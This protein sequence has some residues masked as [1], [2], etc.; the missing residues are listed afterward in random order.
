MPT[1]KEKLD[2]IL[3]KI[4][5]ESERKNILI[6]NELLV[7]KLSDELVESLIREEDLEKKIETLQNT[8]QR[9]AEIHGN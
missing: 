8:I 1:P 4:K 6:T 5:G 2:Q 3:S 9:K 7:E